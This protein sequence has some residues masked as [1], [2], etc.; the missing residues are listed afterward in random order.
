MAKLVIRLK[1]NKTNN[2]LLCGNVCAYG[3]G[4][5]AP[6]PNTPHNELQY[7]PSV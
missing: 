2:K 6:S 1:R 5:C 4:V 7:N 3:E